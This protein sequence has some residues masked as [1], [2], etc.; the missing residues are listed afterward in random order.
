V[1]VG[2]TDQEGSRNA[3]S[4]WVE[5]GTSITKNIIKFTMKTLLQSQNFHG[6]MHAIAKKPEGQIWKL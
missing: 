5:C 1:A 4:Q 6:K 3:K 2:E